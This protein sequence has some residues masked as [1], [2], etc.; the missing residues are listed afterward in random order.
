MKAYELLIEEVLK[1][2]LPKDG[3]GYKPTIKKKTSY[4]RKNQYSIN[5]KEYLKH[6]IGVD[7]TRIDGIDE[8]SGLEIISVT[9]TDMSKMANSRTLFKLVKLRCT[10]KEIRRQG[11]RT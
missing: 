5:L 6:I 1:S 8:I 10:T 11:Y 9:G 2:L 4:V 3:E 7:V